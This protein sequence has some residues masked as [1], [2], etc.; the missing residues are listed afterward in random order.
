MKAHNIVHIDLLS[1]DTEG[2]ELEILRSIDFKKIYIDIII[3]ENNYQ[4]S[5]IRKLLESKGYH[6]VLRHHV[7]ELYV[8]S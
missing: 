4:I 5:G 7:D 8:R 1:I 3:V 6:F 2:S